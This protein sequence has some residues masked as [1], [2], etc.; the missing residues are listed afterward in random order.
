MTKLIITYK[1]WVHC[2]VNGLT[3]EDLHN[4]Y[5]GLRVF[6]PNARFQPLYKMGRWD[7]YINFF[8]LTGVTYTNLLPE[9]F[10]KI[11]IKQYDIE[12]NFPEDVT[13]DPDLGD[14]IDENYM[15]DLTWYEGHRL[16][17]Q[18]IILEEHQV[19]C[20][21]AMLLN[22]K[23]LLEA[24]TS[25]GKTLICGALCRKVKPFG[26]VVL[27]VDGKD[28]CFQTADELNKFGCDAGVVGCGLR[29]F[30]HDVSV[31]TWQ[32]INSISK[33]SKDSLNKEELKTL[34]DGVVAMIFDEVHRCK[35]NEVKKVAEQVFN[36][37]PI[38]W[39]LTGT[40]PKQK[41][42]YY[43]LVT[44]IGPLLD[45]NVKAKELQDKGFLSNCQVNCIRLKDDYKF[46]TWDDEKE[47][48][49]SNTD[50]L[51]FMAS[52]I[53][54][55]VQQQK[56]TLVLVDRI[57]TGETLEKMLIKKGVDA[58]F[59]QG[60]VKSAKRFE[61]YKKFANEDNKCV[62]AIDKI[63]STGLNIPRLFNIV[64]I[65]YGKAFTK[66]IQ[67]I[68]RGLRRALDKDFVT[69]YDISSTTHYSREHFNNRIH[70]YEDAQYPY[71]VMNIDKWK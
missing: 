27:I 22:H 36:N 14:P 7:G 38:R 64:F 49:A 54:G 19:R 48:L 35:G 34:V 20:V 31:C 15:S 13:L 68:G 67:S 3:N 56:N 52:L 62:I 5:N 66:T 57:V 51:A 23:G 33:K 44:A 70:Y 32:T 40:I 71:Q 39:G 29:E 8:G 30:G 17:G 1:D 24:A 21:N 59:L 55:I 2:Q 45:E 46:F 6:N 41:I 4:V 18:P 65:D 12:E 50:R 58:I 43:N 63:A 47:Y 28:L 9:L 37:V 42:D 61:E 60:S 10:S 69:I 16:A 11:N 53:S 25:A 26:K